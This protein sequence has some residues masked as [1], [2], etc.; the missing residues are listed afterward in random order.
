MQANDDVIY[1][2]AVL[3]PNRSLSARGLSFVMLGFGVISFLC[4]IAFWR[5]GALPVAGFFGLDV[6]LLWLFLRHAMKR[7]AEVTQI[8]ITRRQ[9]RLIHRR[10]GKPERIAELPAGFAR[11]DPEAVP[12]RASGGIR[13]AHGHQAFVIGRY[14]TLKECDALIRAARL[15]L[16]RAQGAI[17]APA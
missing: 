5:F 15:G 11:I 2:D 3:T 1:F 9:I 13:I 14:L 6:L 10:P 12:G 17:G 8:T 7:G 16:R 4:G